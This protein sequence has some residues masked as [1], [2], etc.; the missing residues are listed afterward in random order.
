MIKHTM[1]ED[2]RQLIIK[3]NA[4]RTYVCLLKYLPQEGKQRTKIL[5]M[6]MLLTKTTLVGACMRLGFSNLNY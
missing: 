4:A 6:S 1:N 5:A 2:I 3:N